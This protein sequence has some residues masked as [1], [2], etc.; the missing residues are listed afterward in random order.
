MTAPVMMLELLLVGVLM[1]TFLLMLP[2][3]YTEIK[4]TSQEN[5]VERHAMSL[6]NGFFSL[7]TLTYSDGETSARAVLDQEKL[8][9]M[10]MKKTSFIVGWKDYLK[11]NIQPT[12]VVSK[13]LSEE[14]SYPESF[15]LITVLDIDSNEGWVGYTIDSA[16]FGDFINCFIEENE[17]ADVSK[18]FEIESRPWEIFD[19]SS[20]TQSFY[21]TVAISWRGF[22]VSI[23][24]SDGS[25]HTGLMKVWLVEK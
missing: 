16:G 9:C 24:Y 5:E 4:A 8:D 23:R 14:L 19:I 22:P 20:C 25:I 17:K 6:A 18:L 12:C 7:P 11:R 21:S 13:S 15:S 2:G 1:G 10:M 3:K